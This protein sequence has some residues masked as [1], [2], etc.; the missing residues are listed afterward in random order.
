MPFNKN[1]FTKMYIS[2]QQLA[3]LYKIRVVV[4]WHLKQTW[5][6]LPDK[7]PQLKARFLPFFIFLNITTVCE[8]TGQ[9][10]KKV[11]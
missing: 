2:I 1:I 9:K 5:G 3:V 10:T 8:I 7:L 11:T 6:S 4:Q